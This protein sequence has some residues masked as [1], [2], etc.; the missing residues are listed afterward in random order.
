MILPA[1]L[2]EVYQSAKPL[3][4]NDDIQRALD[5]IARDITEKLG[6]SDP[7][8]ICVM[9]GGLMTMGNLLPRLQ[10]ALVTDYVHATRYG[11]ESVGSEIS[12]V[13]KS[14]TAIKGRTVLLVDDILDEGV[15]LA[16]IKKEYL[17]QGAAEVYT[18]VLIDKEK[19]RKNG[20]IPKADFFGLKVSADDFVFGYGLDYKGYLRNT[21]GI[22]AVAPQHK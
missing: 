8:V 5:N 21:P 6:H 2:L 20:G 17:S 9:Q 7:V 14:S 16:S 12:W 11:N 22:Y 4:N 13:V 10:F 1:P 19:P 3:F 15:T 18:A